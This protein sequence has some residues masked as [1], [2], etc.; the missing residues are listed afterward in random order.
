[1]RK[2]FSNSLNRLFGR[3]KPV[4]LESELAKR[5]NKLVEENPNHNEIEPEKPTEKEQEPVVYELPI[6][7]VAKRKSKTRETAKTIRKSRKRIARK[8]RK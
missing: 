3:R 6:V 5:I 8:A 4:T 7:P 1:M 2:F